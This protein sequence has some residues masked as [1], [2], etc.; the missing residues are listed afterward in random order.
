VAF[1]LTVFLAFKHLFSRQGIASGKIRDGLYH[2]PILPYR[3]LFEGVKHKAAA[4]EILEFLHF[5]QT[6]KIGC[7]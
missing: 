1:N 2:M 5:R 7:R 3:I 6:I 4:L